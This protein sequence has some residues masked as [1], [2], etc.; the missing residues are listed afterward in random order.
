MNRHGDLPR[1]SPFLETHRDKDRDRDKR[2]LIEEAGLHEGRKGREG[3]DMQRR[4][5]EGS[6]SA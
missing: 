5:E 3:N 2:E 1:S 4:V 6:L